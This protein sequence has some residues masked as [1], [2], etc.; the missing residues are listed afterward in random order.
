MA[1][2][3]KWMHNDVIWAD[4]FL[5]VFITHDE[6][7]ISENCFKMF[8]SNSDVSIFQFCVSLTKSDL[9]QSDKKTALSFC[10][11]LLGQLTHIIIMELA[12][13][14]PGYFYCHKAIVWLIFSRH[15]FAFKISI[16]HG[17]SLSLNRKAIEYKYLW[18][19]LMMSK[20]K[21]SHHLLYVSPPAIG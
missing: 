4:S 17:Q 12:D 6:I 1:A 3:S 11:Q 7:L 21:N 14:E 19:A 18:I 9:I 5:P 13:L 15:E 20:A 2:V 16:Y 8:C 10:V